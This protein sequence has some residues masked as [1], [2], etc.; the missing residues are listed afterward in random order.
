MTRTIKEI[1][2]EIIVEK[3]SLSSLTDLGY[4]G[5]NTELL[6]QDLNS[7]SKVAVWRLWAYITAVAIYFHE[8]LWS[9]YRAEVEEKLKAI[10]GTDAWLVSECKK[11]QNGDTLI[12]NSDGTYSYASLKPEDQ[13][14][15]RV[16]VTGN[17]GASVVKVA[18]QDEEEG[19][20]R[21]L[22]AEEL[23]AFQGYLGLIQYAGSSIT[24]VSNDSDQLQF[25]IEVFH[26]ALVPITTLRANVQL[27][28]NDY[29]ANLEFNGA[30]RVIKLIDAIQAVEGVLDVSI[31]NI[32]A[33]ADDALT[34]TSFNRIYE[35]SS[36][37]FQ[38][39]SDMNNPEVLKFSVE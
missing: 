5:D 26:N 24:A 33:K 14:I 30:F 22:T 8:K 17:F 23:T 25:S 11:F 21:K 34:F 38:I 36:G 31:H 10:P 3:E 32:E 13:V 6:L 19:P 20:L 7:N 27:A 2:S 1:Y 18:S 29:L 15:K 35:P 39:M 37:Y 9:L 28:I 12:F 16:A 4:T